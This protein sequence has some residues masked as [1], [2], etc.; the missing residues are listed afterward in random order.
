MF[1]A[2]SLATFILIIFVF[3][4]KL[5]A[6]CGGQ[7]MNSF[8]P[9][10]AVEILFY[11]VTL[12][13]GVLI[14][15]QIKKGKNKLTP[16]GSFSLEDSS[17]EDRFIKERARQVLLI[18]VAYSISVIL[19]ITWTILFKTEPSALKCIYADNSAFVLHSLNGMGNFIL[20]L[21]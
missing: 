11:I 4:G 9:F 17:G 12:V 15:K 14:W 16:K 1:G 10:F 2:I 20:I 18:L 3:A 8:Y 13:F 21:N 6:D 19:R 7:F 5:S